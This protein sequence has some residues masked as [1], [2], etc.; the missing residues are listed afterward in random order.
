M[1]S[2]QIELGELIDGKL[3]WIDDEVA[4]RLVNFTRKGDNFIE[5]E[6][7][8]IKPYQHIAPDVYAFRV[9]SNKSDTKKVIIDLGIFTTTQP[10]E[11]DSD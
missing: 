9:I 3:L 8:R 10:Q 2:E 11:E 7:E 4:Y 1:K 6:M 5:I